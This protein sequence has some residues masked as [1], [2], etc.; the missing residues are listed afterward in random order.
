MTRRH[1]NLKLNQLTVLA[2]LSTAVLP[3]AT[4]IEDL[5]PEDVPPEC[6]LACAPITQL[7]ERCEAA[8]EQQLG[9]EAVN[10][11]WATGK[12]RRASA[13]DGGNGGPDRDVRR[14]RRR[15]RGARRSL[16]RM[17]GSRLDR[18]QEEDDGK[19]DGEDSSEDSDDSDDSDSDQS[20]E[21]EEEEEEENPPVSENA[22]ETG[23]SEE[24]AAEANQEA[25]VEAMRACV[26]EETGFDVAVAASGCAACIAQNATAADADEGEL[27]R[28]SNAVCLK[29]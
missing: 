29:E 14:G 16:Q 5:D 19:E 28:P 18:R 25:A 12:Q 6:A 21:E 3:G 4:A 10:R 1:R 22:A 11:R 8:A 7:T 13:V 23:G 27:S 9:A 24:A 20:D 15:Q 2:V 26:C 17:S